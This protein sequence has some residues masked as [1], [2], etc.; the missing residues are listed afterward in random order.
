M[1]GPNGKRPRIEALKNG[2]LKVSGLD[3]VTDTDGG[4]IDIDDPVLLCRCG[5]SSR[6]PFCDGTHAR[7]GYRSHKLDGRVPDRMHDYHGKEIIIHDNRGVCSHAEHCVRDLP[8]VFNREIRPWIRPDGA[9]ADAVSRTIERCPSG[10]LSFTRDGVLHKDL[11]RDAAIRVD[12]CGPYEVTGGPELVDSE[13]SLPESREHY[14]LCRCGASKNKPFC[15][16]AHWNAPGEGEGNEER[17]T[18]HSEEAGDPHHTPVDDG[19]EGT[20]H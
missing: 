5:H 9:P 11:P 2:P 3:R 20:S 16:G 1:K 4:E 10:A 8:A 17:I 14:T 19:S 15:D 18:C 7:V 6:K 12:S 13:G